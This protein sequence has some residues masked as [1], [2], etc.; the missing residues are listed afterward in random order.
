MDSSKGH[1]KSLS[2]YNF[3]LPNMRKETIVRLEKCRAQRRH[4]TFQQ[5]RT[6]CD[7]V[8]NIHWTEQQ[9]LR[10]KGGHTAEREAQQRLEQYP[11]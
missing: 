8:P 9:R 7:F 5:V 2:S 6:E 11:K 10:L 3:A 1:P 4:T